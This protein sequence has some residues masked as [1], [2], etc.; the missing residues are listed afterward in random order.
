MF[1][2]R[3]CVDWL[4]MRRNEMKGEKKKNGVEQRT[5]QRINLISDAVQKSFERK[6]TRGVITAPRDRKRCSSV[7]RRTYWRRVK[8]SIYRSFRSMMEKKKRE[9]KIA[10]WGKTKL[11]LSSALC[12][13]PPL[14]QKNYSKSFSSFSFPSLRLFGISKLGSSHKKSFTRRIILHFTK[15]AQMRPLLKH[16]ALINFS[17][18][19]LEIFLSPVNVKSGVEFV[20]VFPTLYFWFFFRGKNKIWWSKLTFKRFKRYGLAAHSTILWASNERPSAANVTSTRS[21][22]HLNSCTADTSDVP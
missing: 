8:A 2:L 12:S 10:M 6:N 18:V 16:R 7:K 1:T 21:P 17:A 20:S 4:K 5:K 13:I 19:I 22:W 9:K 11:F 14:L 3:L 15:C